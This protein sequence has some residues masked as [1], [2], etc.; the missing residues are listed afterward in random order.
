M[1]MV[2][3]CNL[4]EVLQR[5]QGF[6]QRRCI[7]R[8]THSWY[9]CVCF[10]CLL[11]TSFGCREKWC[12]LIW[13][14]SPILPLRPIE[15]RFCLIKT[16]RRFR[17]KW[18]SNVAVCCASISWVVL[19]VRNS[20]PYW[21]RILRSLVV[22]PGPTAKKTMPKPLG[23]WGL[24]LRPS[25]AKE[26]VELPVGLQNLCFGFDFDQS[27]ENVSPGTNDPSLISWCFLG[28]WDNLNFRTV[29]GKPVPKRPF[30][31]DVSENWI[32]LDNLQL[33]NR[34]IFNFPITECLKKSLSKSLKSTLKIYQIVNQVLLPRAFPEV[35]FHPAHKTQDSAANAPTPQLWKQVQ[36]ELG[37][38]GDAWTAG[39]E[40]A[41]FFLGDS[42]WYPAKMF[43]KDA[44]RFGKQCFSRK[45]IY[46]YG[47]LS[48]SMSVVPMVGRF[49]PCSG[50]GS[51][52]IF[53]CFFPTCQVRA[54]RI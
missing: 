41:G 40:D 7:S 30:P 10:F 22:F 49:L 54:Y 12:K 2:W 8:I 9:L 38:S 26:N 3:G 50:W 19:A 4:G 39:P 37:T 48:T 36:P 14:F 1:A 13:R 24:P 16:M 31:E 35:F 21:R 25:I 29:A 6:T 43:C 15:Y 32:D 45:N 51:P 52:L 23:K 20:V 11:C 42:L 33:Q 18:N 34:S 28:V 5:V 17:Q 44:K 46:I 27:L 53:S 47:G